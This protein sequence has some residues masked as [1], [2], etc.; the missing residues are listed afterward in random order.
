MPAQT[1]VRL[2]MP[3]RRGGRLWTA[4]ARTTGYCADY[5]QG[6][7]PTGR[8]LLKTAE[9]DHHMPLFRV[10][11]E[12]RDTPWP[13]LLNFWGVRPSGNQSRGARGEML[14]E[15]NYRRKVAIEHVARNPCPHLAQ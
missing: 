6:N 14:D 12:Q 10:W 15:A 4:P 5:S 11:R 9:V 13:T 3:L 7:V 8:R 1:L 2:G